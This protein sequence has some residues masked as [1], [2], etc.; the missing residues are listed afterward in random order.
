L[1][2]L[3]E[4]QI[5]SHILAEEL[6]E[7]YANDEK[8]KI[9][10]GVVSAGMAA[11]NSLIG[12]L[13]FSFWDPR[14][15]V[16]R[17]KQA[18]R[19][20]IGTVLRDKNVKALVCKYSGV[21]GNL[22][23]VVSVEAIQERGKKFNKE[24][25]ELDEKQCEMRT[26]GTAHLVEIMNDYDLLPTHNFKFGS[27]PDAGGLRSANMEIKIHTGFTRWLLDR[28]RNGMCKSC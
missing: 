13:N 2:K 11:Q 20:G 26:K 10:I 14:R 5:D 23:N 27:H 19:G 4:N 18:G 16:C 25:R 24:I 17:L 9:N 7:M 28:M 6:T 21:R 8:D 22:N 12:M 15:K 3:P 1:K